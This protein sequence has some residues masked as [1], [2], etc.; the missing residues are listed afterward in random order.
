MRELVDAQAAAR[1]AGALGVV[2]HEEL[3][4]DPAVNEVVRGAAQAVVEPLRLRLARPLDDA[5]LHEPVAHEQGGGDPGLDRLL[6][7]R[8]DHEPVHHRVHGLDVRF[9]ERDLG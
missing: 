3:R 8:A 6:L 4:L 7:P 9:V 2:K 5:D 1:P